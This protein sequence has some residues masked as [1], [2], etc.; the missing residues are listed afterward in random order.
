MGT[1]VPL[2]NRVGSVVSS[3][4][5]GEFLAAKTIPVTA[6]FRRWKASQKAIRVVLLVLLLV[7]PFR[8]MP[9]ALLIRNGKL[10]NLAYTVTM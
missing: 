10:R 4:H 9:R 6:V 2:P 5:F 7:T 3:R 8:K 1:G